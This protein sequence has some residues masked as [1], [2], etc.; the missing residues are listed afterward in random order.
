MLHDVACVRT[1]RGGILWGRGTD[2][3][4]RASVY[5]APHHARGTSSDGAHAH[6][7]RLHAEAL[8]RATAVEAAVAAATA[9][10]TP[11]PGPTK[12]GR[13][14]R[15]APTLPSPLASFFALLAIFAGLTLVA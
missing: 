13:D 2:L 9:T 14:I 11:T 8:L 7:A 6:E 3:S 4:Q 1:M 15:R 5:R 10:A 12:A